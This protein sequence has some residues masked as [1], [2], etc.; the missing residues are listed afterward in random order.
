MLLMMTYLYHRSIYTYYYLLVSLA[1]LLLCKLFEDLLQESEPSLYF[2]MMRFEL[3]PLTFAFPWIASGFVGHLAV[4][5][6]LHVWDRI[7]GHDSLLILPVLGA[8]IIAFRKQLLMVCNMM[9]LF[10]KKIDL[11]FDQCLRLA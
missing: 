11:V 4:D 6:V 7:I 8:A 10:L 2:L 3:S 5:Q 9:Y 1:L